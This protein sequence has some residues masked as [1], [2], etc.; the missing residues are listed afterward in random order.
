VF[1]SADGSA[2]NATGLTNRTV[3]ALA[4]EAIHDPVRLIAGTDAQSAGG[5]LPMFESLDAGATWRQLAPAIAG[6]M[7]IKLVAGPLPPTG[8]V[9]PLLAGT[10]TG[11][12]QSTDNGATFNPLSGGGL[13]LHHEPPRPLLRRE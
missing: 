8:N 4:V 11:L 12:F 6:T 7:T 3:S 9:R 2:W 10:N 13:R 5:G 1:A